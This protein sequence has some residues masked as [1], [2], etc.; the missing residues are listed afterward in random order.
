MFASY[1]CRT[2][3]TVASDT[4]L[5]RGRVTMENRAVRDRVVPLGQRSSLQGHSAWLEE[6]GLSKHYNDTALTSKVCVCVCVCVCVRER[7]RE[8]ESVCVD[9]CVLI[10]IRSQNA[11]I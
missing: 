8:R 1:N 10:C 3:A 6:R 7:E 2:V 11:A 5:G 9:I 4:G